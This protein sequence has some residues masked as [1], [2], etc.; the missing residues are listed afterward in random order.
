MYTTTGNSI[1]HTPDKD[2][3]SMN[4]NVLDHT[5]VSCKDLLIGTYK[6]IH[7]Q[8]IKPWNSRAKETR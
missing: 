4:T 8:H 7:T 5:P 3:E 2:M 6:Y 1:E